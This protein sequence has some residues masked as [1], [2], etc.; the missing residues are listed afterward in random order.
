MKRRSFLAMLGFAP[1]VAAVPAVAARD[2]S[3]SG[4]FRMSVPVSTPGLESANIGTLTFSD[5]PMMVSPDGKL[6]MTVARLRDEVVE[7]ADDV[8]RK[9]M[10]AIE[11]ATLPSVEASA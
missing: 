8:R 5:I 3:A 10:D 1:V 11:A 2:M 6:C 9:Y 4:V 7:G